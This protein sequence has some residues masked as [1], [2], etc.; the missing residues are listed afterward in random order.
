MAYTA[1]YRR[2]RPGS[3]GALIGQPHIGRALAAAVKKNNFVHAYL[4]CGPR[5]TGKTSTARILARAINCEHPTPE[6]DPCGSCPACVREQQGESMD[7][8]EIDGAS[9]R[10]IDE[11]RDLRERV[12]YAPAQ[13]KYKIYIIDEVHMLTNDAFNALLKTLEE[14]PAHVIFIFATTAPH[15]LPPTVISRCQR[16]DFRRIGDRDIAQHLL[17]IAAREHLSL[18]EDAAA[19]IAKK[20]EGGMRDAVSLLDQCAGTA[21]AEISVDTVVNLLGA[22]DREFVLDL[23]HL[24]MAKNT[25]AVLQCVDRLVTEGKDLRQSLDELLEATRDVLMALLSKEA[26]GV[27]TPPDWAASYAPS[28]YVALLQALSDVDAKMRYAL[29]PRIS[30]ELALIR[31]CGVPDTP[32]GGV[33]AAEKAEPPRQAERSAP[34]VPETPPVPAEKEKS[35]PAPAAA[36]KKSAKPAPVSGD[37]VTKPATAAKPSAQAPVSIGAL[38][39]KWPEILSRVEQKN[40]GAHT[41]LREAIPDRIEKNR[42]ILDFPPAMSIFMSSILS[43][44][45]Y[46]ILIE[47]IINSI[48]RCTLSIDGFIGAERV[49]QMDAERNAEAAAAALLEEAAL[50]VPP[51]TEEKTSLF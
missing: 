12:K 50:D 1:L 9:N 3:F 22:V 11:I 47:N 21:E 17:D 36:E 48:M 38:R 31:A 20:A 49:L 13:E 42:L 5:G 4:F 8:I 39:Q 30:L 29:S 14:P 28:D 6:G 51:Q 43:P 44:D 37:A 35:A 19:L 18:L 26:S 10:G 23:L 32:A 16:F 34:P 24:L 25:V 41:I 15:K 33:P 40:A 2:Y 45:Q 7:T 27:E 46:K